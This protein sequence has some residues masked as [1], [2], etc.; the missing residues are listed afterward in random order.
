MSSDFHEQCERLGMTMA[1][2]DP[3]GPGLGRAAVGVACAVLAALLVAS[4]SRTP[5]N[6]NRGSET[7]VQPGASG[8]SPAV[9]DIISRY[10][11]LDNS[12][13]STTRLKASVQSQNG[14]KSEAIQLTI[15]RKKEPDGTQHYMIDFT[16]PPEERDR[17]ALINVTPAGEIEAIRYT[18]STNSFLTARSAIDEESLFGLTLQE[19]VGGQPQKY[20]YKLIGEEQ[21]KGQPAYRVEGMLKP[22]AE[23]RFTRMVMLISR[24][25]Y[26]APMIEAYD[27]QGQLARKLVIARME[28]V[29]GNWL[30]WQWTIDNQEQHKMIDFQ[31]ADV[32]FNQNLPESN[33]SREFLKKSS[34]K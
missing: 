18:Q 23:S 31:V 10:E 6:E 32:K 33:F 9:D 8:A 7:P 28:Q 30:R 20:D 11:S 1:K 3:A 16:A 24:E 25:N 29:S 22:G 12:V 34:S 26:T 13:D 21:Y 17:D 2:R 5:T 4:C 15:F 14:S 27:K 19:L